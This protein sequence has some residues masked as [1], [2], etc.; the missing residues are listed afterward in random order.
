MTERPWLVEAAA[1]PGAVGSSPL[2][3]EPPTGAARSG[4]LR[5]GCPEDLDER[6]APEHLSWCRCSCHEPDDGYADEEHGVI[7]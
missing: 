1:L 3:P 4:L 5:C 6:T 2:A 7:G